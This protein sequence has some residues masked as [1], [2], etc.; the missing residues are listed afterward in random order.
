M[1]VELPFYRLSEIIVLP[2]SLS[3]S[4]RSL[5]LALSLTSPSVCLSLSCCSDE[6]S[7][8][9]NCSAELNHPDVTTDGFNGRKSRL[10][11]LSLAPHLSLSFSRSLSI[12]LLSVSLYL[13]HSLRSPVT[14]SRNTHLALAG[15]KLR[16]VMLAL[17]EDLS[18]CD[19]L[20]CWNSYFI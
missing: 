1:H 10:Y 14:S 15:S 9:S 8:C 2:S 3:L 6:A 12:S 4:S 7:I 11:V 20:I 16:Y 17:S 5:S 19:V 13:S 18:D